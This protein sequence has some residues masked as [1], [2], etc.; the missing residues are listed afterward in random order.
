MKSFNTAGISNTTNMKKCRLFLGEFIS[1]QFDQ[2]GYE[3]TLLKFAMQH[4]SIVFSRHNFITL[5]VCKVNININ[6]KF[7]FYLFEEFPRADLG[8]YCERKNSAK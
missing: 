6:K 7:P 3:K 8:K 5:K 4:L 1:S 2:T